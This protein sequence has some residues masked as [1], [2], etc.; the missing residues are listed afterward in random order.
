MANFFISSET[1]IQRCSYEKLFWEYAA[2]LKKNIHAEV[3]KQF[4]WN[5]T[6]AFP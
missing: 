6:T 4:Y 5:H 1:A 2:N 3:W